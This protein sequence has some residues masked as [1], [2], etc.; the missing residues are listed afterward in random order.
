MDPLFA[1]MIAATSGATLTAITMTP[2]DVVKTRLQTQLPRKQSTAGVQTCRHAPYVQCARSMSSLAPSINSVPSSSASAIRQTIL[3]TPSSSFP[4]PNVLRHGSRL[5]Q[6][7]L[8]V[9]LYE[10]GGIRAQRVTGFWDALLQV[11][12]FEGIRGLWKGAGTTL[13][14]AVPS[15]SA[16]MITY[17]HLLNKT[18]PAILPPSALTPLLSGIAARTIISTVASPLELLRTSLQSTPLN[19][20]VPHTLRSVLSS[21]RS[22]A[23]TQ[24]VTALWRGLS[25]TLWRDVPFSGVYWASYETWK[26]T[27]R[28]EYN[29]TGAPYEFVSGAVSGITAALITHPFDVAKTRR[30]ALLLSQSGVPARTMQF[31]TKII[32]QEGVSALY[33]GVTPRLAKIA[34]ACGI[35]IASYEGVGRYFM[36]QREELP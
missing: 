10:A 3:N 34:P 23:R 5:I 29:K 25:P 36:K 31:L 28:R 30:Q 14:I 17:D 21:A 15:Q 33:A 11:A 19:P 27:L 35:M 22:L 13:M 1:K 32:R 26:S 18:F 6:E 2:F 16:Y 12:R 24:G 4:S 9:C 20:T 7:D 8:C